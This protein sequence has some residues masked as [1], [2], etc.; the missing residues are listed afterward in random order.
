MSEPHTATGPKRMRITLTNDL[1]RRSFTLKAELGTPLTRHQLLR[2][3]KALAP[4]VAGLGDLTVGRYAGSLLGE[5]GPQRGVRLE[6]GSSGVVILPAHVSDDQVRG[7]RAKWEAIRPEDEQERRM[8]DAT[9]LMCDRA[10]EG[11][12]DYRERAAALIA[13]DLQAE[14][15]LHPDDESMQR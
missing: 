6:R 4:E 15:Q 2:A 14:P 7:Y 3:R 8:K 13:G 9:I 10:L 1:N 11:D 12:R 5:H